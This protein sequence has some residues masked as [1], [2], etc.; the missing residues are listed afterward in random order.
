MTNV[1][2]STSSSTSSSSLLRISGMASGI[3]TDAVVKSMVSNYQ[4]KIDKENQAKQIL[5]WKQDAYRDI[6]KEIKGLQ[7]YFNVTSSKYIL[8]DSST[9]INTATSDTN[10][11][12][13]A[14]AGS[15]AKAG[16]YSIEVSQLAK[17]AQ[18]VGTTLNSSSMLRVTDGSEWS[19]ATLDIGGTKITLDSITDTSGNGSKL[20]EVVANINSKIASNSTL[21][22]KISASPES[23]SI[24]FTNKDNSSAVT[25]RATSDGNQIFSNTIS[26]SSSYEYKEEALS[27]SGATLNIGGTN[28]TLKSITDANGSGTTLDEIVSNINSEIASQTTLAGKVSASYVKEGNTSYIKFTSTNSTTI[29][30]AGALTAG[31]AVNST[32]SSP[33]T[34]SSKLA[35]LPGF[36]SS[37]SFDISYGTTTKTIT[38]SSTDTIQSLMDKVNGATSGAVTMSI[39]DTTGK[40]SFQSKGT[41]S[42]SNI[43][44]KGDMSS[45]GITGADGASGLTQ[46]GAD[47]IVTISEPGKAT[48][49]TT[50]S[51]N[52]F[53]L[54]GMSYNITNTNIGDPANITVTANTDKVVTNF[55][56]FINDYN[57]IISTINTKLTEKQN[58]DYA[59][60]TD[61]QR[62]AMSDSQIKTW[63]D[64]AK[65]G[66]LR[67]DD[68][69]TDVMTQLRGIFSTP[70]YTDATT[71]T[72]VPLSLG[73]YGSNAIGIDTS[74]VIADSGKLVIND[75]TKLRNVIA[76]NMDDFKKMFNG[77]SE[78]PLAKNASGN[79]ENYIGSAKYKEDG[80]FTRMNT[81]LRDYVASPG[82][83]MDGTYT[84]SGSM[85]IFVNKQYDFSASG[86]SSKNTLPDQVYRKTSNI[87]KLKTQMTDAENRYYKQFTALETAMTKLNSQQSQLS[88]MLGT[89]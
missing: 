13:S 64:K 69:L 22:G 73:K 80:L 37:L 63:E 9:N 87:T 56:N 67:N 11:V 52:Q 77:V 4:T 86:T 48:T 75:E 17:Q 40:I 7:D 2:Q 42:A 18:I 39:D 26:A 15:S 71:S 57:T 72:K 30:S 70:V 21:N 85:N 78:T 32:V 60:L 46:I 19:N 43:T 47:A 74:S 54:N 10:S 45:L 12:V 49:I 14:T 83:G 68:Y 38:A 24:K 81:I 5:Q 25:V 66:I 53:T 3:D 20:D 8:G 50:Q 44:I 31:G 59:P 27:W 84:L 34:K 65:V 88:A 23:G 28:I 62:S 89:A 35:D 36:S 79:D 1:L 16:N 29:R 61:D 82:M 41:G 33:I 6:I 51:S 76:N 55:K 58:K